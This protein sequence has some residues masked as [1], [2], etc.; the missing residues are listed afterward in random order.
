MVQK[1]FHIVKIINDTEFIINAGYGDAVKGDKFK[2]IG[3]ADEE[4]IDP[5]TN[6]SLGSIETSKGTIFITRVFEKMSIASSGTRT[7]NPVMS[8]FLQQ[9]PTKFMTDLY[10]QERI[11]LNVDLTQVSGASNRTDDPIQIGDIVVKIET[12]SND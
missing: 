10:K 6:E 4:I 7:V 12:E 5:I 9:N 11:K 1:E 8:S 3:Y 2:I